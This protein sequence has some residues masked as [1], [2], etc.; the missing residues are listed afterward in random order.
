MKKQT[1]KKKKLKGIVKSNLILR[2][3]IGIVFPENN[4]NQLFLELESAEILATYS[5][6]TVRL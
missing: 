2:S 4:I 1:K 6:V 5:A 3:W